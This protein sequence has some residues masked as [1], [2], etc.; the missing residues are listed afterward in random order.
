MPAFEITFESI[1]VKYE[2]IETTCDKCKTKS[3]DNKFYFDTQSF[4]KWHRLCDKCKNKP[5]QLEFKWDE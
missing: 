3:F 2:P 1:Y 4:L 5:K